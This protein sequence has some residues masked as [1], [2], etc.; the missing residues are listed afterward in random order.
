MEWEE[1][2]ARLEVAPRAFR[3]AAE[4]AADPGAAA[5]VLLLAL[6]GEEWLARALEAVRTGGRVPAGMSAAV[7]TPPEGGDPVRALLDEIA[8]R[9]AR[10]FAALQ[11]RG[12]ETWEW[13]G[14]TEDGRPVTAHQ[15]AAAAVALDGERLA[16]LRGGG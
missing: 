9:R 2:L 1:L 4:D 12:I 8:A 14:T 15:V 6:F 13:A 7:G 3:L 10:S 16:L 5:G 11:R